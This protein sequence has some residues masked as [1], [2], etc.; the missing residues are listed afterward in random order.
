MILRHTRPFARASPISS[1]TYRLMV[2]LLAGFL[3]ATFLVASG[4]P[5][6]AAPDTSSC[7]GYPEPRVFLESQDWWQP[8]LSGDE[9]FGHVHGGACFPRTHRPDGSPNA[10]KGT[11]KLDVKVQLHENL[12]ELR[13]VRVDLTDSNANTRVVRV[14]INEYCVE[15]GPRWSDSANGCVWWVPV[16]IDTTRANFDGFQEIRL[17]ASVRHANS[18]AMFSTTGWQLYLDNGKPV[19]HYRANSDGSPREFLE[20]RGWY[21]GAGYTNARLEDRLPYVVSGVW[22]PEV[23]MRAGSGGVDVQRSFASINP[24]FHHGNEGKVILDQVGAYRGKLQ[25]DTTELADGRHRLFLR[26]D[27][28]C[29]GTRGNDCGQRDDGDSLNVSTNSGALALTFYVDN[30]NAIPEDPTEPSEPEDPAE[31]EDPTGPEDPTEP[32]EPSET[33]HPTDPDVHI[34]VA[35]SKN[36]GVN[37]ATVRWDGA[38]GNAVELLIDGAARSVSNTGTYEHVTGTRGNPTMT[39]Q[40]CD[41]EAC[42]PLITVDSW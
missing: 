22:E 23:R 1:P 16:E 19:S 29:D 31:P 6:D 39:Y 3:I 17:G 21:E 32:T 20:G 9:D 18:D 15:N 34:D 10:V 13:F 38:T 41:A 8:T 25:I 2:G 42:S 24:N 27:A 4:T 12:G 28:P 35:T 40:L 26:A 14:D 33:E 30:G 5:G 7:E 36:K 37:I 11:L